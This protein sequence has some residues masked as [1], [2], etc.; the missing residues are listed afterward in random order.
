MQPIYPYKWLITSL[1][2]IFLLPSCRKHDNGA[3]PD[4]GGKNVNDSIF[5]V[6]K[7][8][9]L[10]PD[11]IPDSATFRP[12]SY[13]ATTSMFNALKQY[14]KDDAGN[15]MDRYSFLDDGSTSRALQQGVVGD[16]GFEVGFQTATTLYVVYVYPGSPADKAGIKRG[17]K[18]AAVN[19][20]SQFQQDQATNTLLNN[21]LGGKSATFGFVKPDGSTQQNT[22]AA[23]DYKLNPILYANTFNFNGTK[24]G[25][26][27]FNNFVALSDVKTGI[28]SIYDAW[29]K[30][31]VKQLIIDLRYNGGGLIETAEYLANKMVPAARNNTEMYSQY[32]N[33]NVNTN[34]YSS[35]FTN[36]KAVPYFPTEN[37]TDIFHSEA[38]TYKTAKFQKQGTLDLSR[39][40]FLVTRNTV[41]ASELLYNVLKPTMTTTLV[42]DTTYGKPVGF[43][44]ISFGKYDMYAV[45][46]QIKN[47]AGEGD[48]FKGIK[49]DIKQIDDYTTDWGNLNDPILR[50]ALLDMGIPANQLG[51]SAKMATDRVGRIPVNNLQSTKF[52]GMIQTIRK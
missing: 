31:G 25:Y 15:V 52:K 18:L 37:W 44:N 1:F 11:A 46:F 21:A 40:S 41:S 23:V 4:T 19:G 14:K 32:F 45:S 49:P 20:V 2:L 50:S 27:V 22:L 17:W 13:A 9:Y 3:T 8:I 47:S 30:A 43:I 33:N 7:D 28:D 48:Y 5:F 34:T 42:G 38:T 10:W 35:Y 29:S 39:V 26:F 36:M 6:F 24:V 16:I 51:R 12:S